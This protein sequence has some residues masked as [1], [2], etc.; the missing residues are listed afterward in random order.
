[1]L[2]DTIT[3]VELISLNKKLKSLDDKHKQVTDAKSSEQHKQILLTSIFVDKAKITYSE[4]LKKSMQE[5]S[6]LGIDFL[7]SWYTDFLNSFE[8]PLQGRWWADVKL[9]EPELTYLSPITFGQFIDAKMIVEGGAKND[10]DKWQTTQ[11]LVSIFCIPT[12]K[13][14]DYNYASELNAHFIRSGNVSVRKAIM[15]SVWWDKLNKHINEN[16]TVFQDSG[17][18]R[19]NSD[20]MD[21]HMFRWGW[22]N[23]LKGIAKTKAFDISGSGM[24]SIDCVRETKASDILVWASEEKESNVA[25]NRDMKE[26]YKQH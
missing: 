22:V 17:D 13:K 15:V 24:N 11:Y 21:E 18:I 26:A 10:I 20:N 5:V 4:L 2:I 19:E 23:F 8:L 25:A 1:M 9:S 6:T 12:K 16:Y 14:Y 3:L 7:F